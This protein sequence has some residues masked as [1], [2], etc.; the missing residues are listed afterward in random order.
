M[1]QNGIIY[2]EDKEV[3]LL[4][5]DIPSIELDDLKDI[6]SMD[7]ID[8]ELREKR[9]STYTFNGMPVPRVSEILRVGENSEPLLMWAA[10]LGPKG[11]FAERNK[12]TTIGSKTHE[13]IE[14]FL[15]TGEDA[16]PDDNKVEP[17]YMR[18]VWTAYN[19]FKAWLDFLKVLGYDI[20]VIAIEVPVITPFY[21][22]T[23]DLICRINGKVYVVDFKTSKKISDKYV[24]QTSA[25]AWG[26]N[27]GYCPDLQGIHIDGIGIIRIDKERVNVFE[28]LF[29]N[30]NILWQKEILYKYT[31]AFG[32]FLSAYYHNI[33]I[34]RLFMR[35][36]KNYT[37]S[38]VLGGIM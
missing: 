3:N 31:T 16:Q 2:T 22:G 5:K 30:E 23:A 34:E 13:M 28:D 19:N 14:H 7:T 8:D 18:Y 33:E 26:I 11:F 9:F 25:Y 35:Y 27:N 37:L 29:L 38:S 6:F 32:S 17:G 20:E 12:A 1:V 36:K 21:G 4:S 24:L 10:K 15:T